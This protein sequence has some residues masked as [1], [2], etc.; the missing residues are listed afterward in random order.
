M[1]KPD[2]YEQE[3]LCYSD[4][5]P[6]K[7]R[8]QSS[9]NCCEHFQPSTHTDICHEY[10]DRGLECQCIPEGVKQAIRQGA[11]PEDVM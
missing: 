3:M 9:D 4:E 2:P 7:R 11:N 10:W 1:N 6:C 8:R 5:K